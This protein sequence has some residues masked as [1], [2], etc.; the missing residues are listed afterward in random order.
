MRKIVIINSA[1]NVGNKFNTD[2]SISRQVT[3]S[4][5]VSC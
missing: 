1:L 4:L 3:G 5:R 2:K